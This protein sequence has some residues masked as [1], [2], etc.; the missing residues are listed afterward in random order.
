MHTHTSYGPVSE[1]FNTDT[2]YSAIAEMI[3]YTNNGKLLIARVPLGL[4]GWIPY[5]WEEGRLETA[6][7]MRSGDAIRLA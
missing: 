2:A 1:K 4:R 5:L 7:F 3:S 6:T